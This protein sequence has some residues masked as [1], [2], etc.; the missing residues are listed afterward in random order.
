MGGAPE[1][2]TRFVGVKGPK[3]VYG[4][5]FKQYK[6][7][8][9]AGPLTVAALKGG[10][11]DVANLYTTQS[12]IKQ[13]GFVV[14]DDPKHLVAAENVLPVARKSKMSPNVQSTLTPCRPNSPR[15]TS[16]HW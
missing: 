1:L 13:N 11:I 15:R 6:P 5:D 2:R 10:V 12:T 7:L 4:L 3:Q 8:D 16:P 14:L 9:T